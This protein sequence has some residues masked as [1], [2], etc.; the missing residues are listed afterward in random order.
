VLS[1]GRA[2]STS[3]GEDKSADAVVEERLG[4]LEQAVGHGDVSLITQAAN[5]AIAAA[6]TALV[7]RREREA[8]QS[9]KLDKELRELRDALGGD[10]Q[11]G[12]TDELTGLYTRGAYEQQIEQLCALGGLLEQPP[13]LVL[14]ERLPEVVLDPHERIEP[15]HRLL[16]DEPEVGATKPA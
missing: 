14:I 12:A 7:K 15:R 10:A 4:A 9:A 3:I 2:L 8:R 6:R 11:R 5:A 13:W 16:E 1:L